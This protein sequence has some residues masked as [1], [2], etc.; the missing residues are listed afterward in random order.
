MTSPS[1][2]LRIGA[3][4][5]RFDAYA[6]FQERV[7]LGVIRGINRWQKHRSRAAL[8]DEDRSQL[9]EHLSDEVMTAICE[10]TEFQERE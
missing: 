5:V 8:T 10:V 6:I 9:E 2:K 7:D 4:L 1:E 3:S